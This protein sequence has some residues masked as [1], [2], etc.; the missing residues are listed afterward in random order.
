MK[1]IS[2]LSFLLKV[3]VNTQDLNIFNM[4]LHLCTKIWWIIVFS[5]SVAQSIPINSKSDEDNGKNIDP[6]V[7]VSVKNKK[8]SI[9]KLN[10]LFLYFQIEFMKKFGYLD[11]GNPNSEALYTEQSV[12]QALAKVQVSKTKR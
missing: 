6:V 8:K 2:C 3:V 10:N 4:Q 12:R 9:L 5:F 11:P 1:K 7:A